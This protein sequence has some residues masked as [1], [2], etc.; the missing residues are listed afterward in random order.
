M[1]SLCVAALVLNQCCLVIQLSPVINMYKWRICI[2]TYPEVVIYTKKKCY[3][4]P[5][6]VIHW[7]I[8][9]HI[10][11]QQIF[12]TSNLIHIHIPP[13]MCLCSDMYP[14]SYAYLEFRVSGFLGLKDMHM[15]FE[16]F[17]AFMSG[18]PRYTK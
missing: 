17:Q 9:M 16:P 18:W 3:K 5:A 1:L 7:F 15:C 10:H 8:L 12:F 14:R 6:N 11:I 2:D 4:F 13:N